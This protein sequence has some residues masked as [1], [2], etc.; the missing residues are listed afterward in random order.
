MWIK[1]RRVLRYKRDDQ[2]GD[3]SPSL[4]VLGLPTCAVRIE[5]KASM[6]SHLIVASNTLFSQFLSVT[7]VSPQKVCPFKV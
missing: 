3:S 2:T 4:S 5:G 6:L 7:L 1:N